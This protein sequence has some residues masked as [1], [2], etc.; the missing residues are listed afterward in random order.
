M[1]RTKEE[2]VKEL[3][4]QIAD[5]QEEAEMVERWGDSVCSLHNFSDQAKIEA[6]DELY[7]QARTYLKSFVETGYEPKDAEHYL[8]AAVINFT[9]GSG[10]WPIINSLLG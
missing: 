7:R 10:A 2:R 9:L 3:K 5:L 1:S 4:R 8:Y 6:F